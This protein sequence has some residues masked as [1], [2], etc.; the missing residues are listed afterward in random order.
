MQVLLDESLPVALAEVDCNGTEEN[1]LE[2]G[3]SDSAISSCGLSGTVASDNTI[4]AC[5]N[6]V[7]GALH[8]SATVKQK[9]VDEHIHV[10]D[11]ALPS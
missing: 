7:A 6:P 9:V 11:L 4:L 5:V 2:C 8:H 3:R 10:W 1:L